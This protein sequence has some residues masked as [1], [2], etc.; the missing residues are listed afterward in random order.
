MENKIHDMPKLQSPFIRKTNEKGE[1]IVTSEIAE[2]YDW[3]FNDEDVIATEKLDGT[4]VSINI[5]D[6]IIRGIW[7]R[8]ERIPFFNKGKRRIVEGVYNAYE[9]GYTEFLSDGQHFGECIGE[10][11]NDNPLGIKGQLWIP[12]ETYAQEHLAYKSWGKYPKTYDAIS[13]WFEKDLFS[14]FIMQTQ[15]GKKI[16]PEG[17]VFVKK[18]TGQMAKLRRDM[19][20]WFTGVRHKDTGMEQSKPRGEE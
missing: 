11:I 2:G 20:G 3:V 19:F 18:S 7:N 15:E 16:P 8:T 13:Q 6:G 10:G 14:L 17:I 1:Y 5:E 4:N 12:F 9:R